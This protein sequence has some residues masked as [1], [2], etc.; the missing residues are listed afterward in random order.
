MICICLLVELRLS[1]YQNFSWLKGFDG[2]WSCPTDRAD[3]DIERQFKS[4][5]VESWDEPTVPIHIP[6][7]L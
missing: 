1:E 5:S 6:Y 2:F 4:Q 7:V 3:E